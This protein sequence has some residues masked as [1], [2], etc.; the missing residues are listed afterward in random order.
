MP[1]WG[2]EGAALRG[3][4]YQRILAL[5]YPH[6]ELKAW[7][8]QPVRVLLGEQQDRVAIGSAAPFLVV[9]ARGRKL[10]VQGRTLRFGPK[11]RLGTVSLAPPVRIL[12]GAQPLTLNGSG[13]RGELHLKRDAG[14]LMVVNLVRLDLYLRGVVPYEMPKGWEA[15]AYK[16]QAVVARSYALATMHP[17]AAYDLTDDDRSQVY[18][19]IPA[20]RPETSLALGATA[21]QVLSYG[22]QVIVA[23]YHSSSGGMPP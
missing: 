16:A 19:G 9:D 20:E 7:Q 15:E 18:G 13:Y 12:P 11:L 6:T 4:S 22:G 23:Y 10:H 1:Q 2:A 21:G 5:Y 17:G 14:K 3:W 8:A